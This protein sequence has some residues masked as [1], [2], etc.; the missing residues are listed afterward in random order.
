MHQVVGILLAAGRGLRF[1]PEGRRDKLLERLDSGQTVLKQSALRLSAWVD[2]LVIVTRPGRTQALQASCPGLEADWVEAL[3]ADLGM[4]ASLKA[5]V[6]ALPKPLRGWLIGL[7]DMPWIS[8]QTYQQVRQALDRDGDVVRPVHHGYPGHPVGCA[9]RLSDAML[10]LPVT[11]GLASV[12]RRPDLNVQHLE[13]VD[14]GCIR[15]IDLPA[16]M[17]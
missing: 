17:D 12:F 6:S 4:G 8:P 1:D 3:D 2:R 14:P 16:D 10:S 15:D 11:G 7:A 9:S 5:G 13:V